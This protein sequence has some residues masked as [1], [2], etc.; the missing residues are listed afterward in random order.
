MVAGVG[1]LAIDAINQDNVDS[2]SIVKASI[3]VGTG[4]IFWLLREKKFKIR[5]RNKIQIIEEGVGQGVF[6]CDDPNLAVKV[7]L[8]IANWT[9]MW[10]RPEGPLSALEI[11]DQSA[12]LFLNGI[13][14]R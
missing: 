1:Y 4:Y 11:A 13:C 9:I 14:V 2:S 7:V 8:G 12:D 6:T 5:R 10:Y 3:L